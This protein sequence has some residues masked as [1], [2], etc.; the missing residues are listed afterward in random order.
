MIGRTTCILYPSCSCIPPAPGLV[1]DHCLL[2]EFAFGVCRPFLET[3]FEQNHLKNKIKNCFQE[4]HAKCV[5]LTQRALG[6]DA[7][8]LAEKYR[9]TLKKTKLL[10]S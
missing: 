7:E 9:A 3:Q 5:G 1:A 6:L 2:A 4:M 8:I 10:A